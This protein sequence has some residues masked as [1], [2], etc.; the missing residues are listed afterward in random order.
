MTFSAQVKQEIINNASQ[1]PCCIHAMCYGMLL[2]GKY[3]SRIQISMLTEN[4]FVAEQYVKLL[5]NETGIKTDVIVTEA[6]NYKINIETRSVI[7]KIYDCFSVPENEIK[8]RINRGNLQNLCLDDEIDNCCDRAFLAGAFLSCG[9]ISDP[10]KSYH[11]EYVVPHKQLS[12]DLV[13]VL[14]D[15]GIPSRVIGR[16][17][18]Y[19]VY[20][21]DSSAIENFLNLIG[22][23]NA[24]LQLIQVK[25]EKSVK[26]RINRENNFEFANIAR[27][28]VAVA[29]QIAAIEQIKKNDTYE[30]L[31]DDL[32][33]TAELRVEFQ[34]KSLSA[35]GEEFNPPISRS[36][37]NCK[38][39]RIIA[40]SKKTREEL[41][42]VAGVTEE[43]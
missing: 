41:E 18:V 26:N 8:K 4:G 21:K 39:K 24:E 37:V 12:I 25:V 5:E 13:K 7:R 3:F 14:S 6:E 19:V 23:P 2:F 36:A 43:Q 28:A 32:K 38:L 31:P 17:G 42:A 10:Q 15:N 11:V 16:R 1:A 35:L 27:T 30:F 22:A 33:Q 34:D 9:T 40:F 29:E 20:I